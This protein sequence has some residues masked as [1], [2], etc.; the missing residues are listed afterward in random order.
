MDSTPALNISTWLRRTRPASESSVPKL[1]DGVEVRRLHEDA[2]QHDV[3][4]EVPVELVRARGDVE[5]RKRK[6]FAYVP[7]NRGQAP[8][9]VVPGLDEVAAERHQ[10]DGED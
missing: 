6:H 7:S 5:E 4:M 9:G 10:H 3:R 8:Q 2:E 1:R